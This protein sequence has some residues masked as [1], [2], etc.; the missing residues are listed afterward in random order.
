GLEGSKGESVN[1]LDRLKTEFEPQGMEIVAISGV[2]G[3]GLDKLLYRVYEKVKELKDENIV[4]EQEY[5]PEEHIAEELPYTVSYDE[6]EKMYLIE[7]P[8]IEKMLGYTNLESEK[9]FLFFQKFIREIGALDKL[10]ELGV[11]E[12]DTVKIYGFQFEYLEN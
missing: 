10:K 1:P 3:Q 4:Y 8:R 6:K 2:T 11:R 7:G 9:G 12:G 5:F